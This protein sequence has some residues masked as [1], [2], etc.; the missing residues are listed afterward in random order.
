MSELLA[1]QDLTLEELLSN[2]S[3]TAHCPTLTPAAPGNVAKVLVVDCITGFGQL[4][5]AHEIPLSPVLHRSQS[6]SSA[7]SDMENLSASR[8]A[9]SRYPESSLAAAMETADHKMH[10]ETKRR[11]FGSDMEILIRAFCADKGWNALISRRRRG[12]L[13]C[14]IRE[15]GALGWKVVIRVD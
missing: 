4:P 2:Y 7:V 3:S 1:K 9:A 10:Q 15:A 11:Q 6:R 8:D 12:C 13:A 14:A 5:Q